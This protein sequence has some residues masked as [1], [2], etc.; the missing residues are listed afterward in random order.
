MFLIQKLISVFILS[1]V[2]F[3]II[4][5][6]IGISNIK[7]RKYKSGFLLFAISTITYIFSCEFFADSIILNLEKK[8]AI[9]SDENIQKG[10]IYILLG[11]GILT[12]T[13]GGNVPAKNVY[14]RILKTAQLYNKNPKEIYISGGSPLQNKES[15]SSV[16]KKELI[17]LGI[18]ENN[19]IIEEKSKTTKENSIFIK[20]IMKEKNMKSGIIITSAIHMPRS[21][22]VF[23]DS[24]LK[25]YPAPCD[26]TAHIEKQNFFAYVPKFKVL[27]DLYSAFWEYIGLI[28]YKIR[29]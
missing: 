22:E 27:K 23:K 16:Y 1:P 28:Y 4:L 25:F 10:D 13:L 26:F 14:S 18:P 2:P 29:Y 7:D 19:I 5:L 9:T 6:L 17:L 12:D 8:Y 24:E 20:N 11:G 15:E 3:I 21:M